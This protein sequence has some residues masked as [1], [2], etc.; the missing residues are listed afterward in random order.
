V[1][2]KSSAGLTSPFTLKHRIKLRSYVCN[3]VLMS[4]RKLQLLR[5]LCLFEKRV[6]RRIFGL[7]RDEVTGE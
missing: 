4:C 3:F 1:A 5:D 7:R 6:L 2:V